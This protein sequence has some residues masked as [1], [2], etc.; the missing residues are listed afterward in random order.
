M[1]H[2]EGLPVVLSSPWHCFSKGLLWCSRSVA[3][4]IEEL[5]PLP[6][7]PLSLA[8]AGGCLLQAFM[9]NRALRVKA[10]GTA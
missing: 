10:E 1:P 6:E 9:E 7:G 4:S 8:K 2:Q 3:L 5:G